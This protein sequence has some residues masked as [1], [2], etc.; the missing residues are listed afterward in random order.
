MVDGRTD[1]GRRLDGY[2]ISSPCEPNGSG[3]LKKPFSVNISLYQLDWKSV[4]K[5]MR[6]HALFLCKHKGADQLHD[7]RAADQ[8]LCFRYID[9]TFPLLHE[10]KISSLWSSSV[11]VQSGL[12]QAWSETR[13]QVFP[14]QG[15]VTEAIF[16]ST[17]SVD[18]TGKDF[19]VFDKTSVW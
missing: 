15:S 10:S 5:P 6:K 11:V 17:C 16:C 18:T 7:E 13:R 19:C 12:C 8:S 3:E 1:D 9:S 4:T 2:T 14:Q